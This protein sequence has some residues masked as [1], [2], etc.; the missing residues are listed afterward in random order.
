M[1]R[2]TWGESGM[3]RRALRRPSGRCPMQ[4][5]WR[6][7]TS[8]LGP[9]EGVR[10]GALLPGGPPA[11]GHRALQR[12]PVR[13]D[14][15]VHRLVQAPGLEALGDH[16]APAGLPSAPHPGHL[17]V[18]RLLR[19]PAFLEGRPH[20]PHLERATGQAVDV[21]HGAAVGGEREGARGGEA[22]GEAPCHRVD[23]LE[24]QP[25]VVPGVVRLQAPRAFKRRQLVGRAAAEGLA[26]H[27]A[28]ELGGPAELG[29]AVWPL[30]AQ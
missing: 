19:L 6:V 30:G 13:R 2:P 24:R 8:S 1:P 5:P 17:A 28:D 10:G 18:L 27:G 16:Q 9:Q 14:A 3:W 25:A 11:R 21:S 22:R 12:G 20:L 23:P 29:A 7:S 4:V 15:R 26:G